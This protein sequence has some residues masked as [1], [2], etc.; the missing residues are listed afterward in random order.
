MELFLVVKKNDSINPVSVNWLYFNGPGVAL[1]QSP[2][3]SLQIPG[4]IEFEHF[5]LGGEGVAFRDTTAT[6]TG[7]VF[8]NDGPDLAET[9]DQNGN[10]DLLGIEN[11][12]W[13]E[14]TVNVQ[15][16][17]TYRLETRLTA[18]TTGARFS[19]KV[20]GLSATG[21]IS[22]PP[23]NV[24]PP[25]LPVTVHDVFLKQGTQTI[26]FEFDQT[27][28]SRFNYFSWVLT[29]SNQPPSVS[30][31]NPKPGSIFSLGN[32][33]VIEAAAQDPDG[34]RNVEFYFNGT[35]LGSDTNAPYSMETSGLS[36]GN[37]P[38]V[39]KAFDRFGAES[40]SQIMTTIVS[41]SA[42]MTGLP[43]NIPGIVQA[44]NYDVGGTNVAY[45]D[46]DTGNNGAAYRQDSVDI[47]TTSD[48]GA[49]YNVGWTSAGEWLIYT[50]NAVVDGTYTLDVRV[51]SSGGAGTFHVEIDGTNIT[52]PLTPGDTGGW[53]NWKTVSTPGI[54]IGAG[55]HKLRLSL[56]TPGGNGGVGNYNW[57]RFTATSTNTIDP[58]LESSATVDGLYTKENAA[59]LS[60]DKKTFTLRQ[61]ME[62]QFY[63]IRAGATNRIMSITL[64]DGFLIIRLE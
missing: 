6:N 35:L 56:D 27:T 12:E 23:G 22:I 26:R 19:V 32:S 54:R 34:I 18:S 25:W 63:R 38:I 41:G 49:G 9:T 55:L 13:L 28:E 57:L 5:D 30:I 1:P 2:F 59:A 39:V 53:Q 48:V 15:I 62:T 47:E 43:S 51:A 29:Q 36:A 3:Q 31:S 61:P 45:F 7:N 21:P 24:L 37:Y 42:P 17:G 58:V 50:I 46:S 8:R 60:G 52:G 33:F 4:R 16:S 11:G 64:A 14:Y 20:N 40:I 10:F 44:E